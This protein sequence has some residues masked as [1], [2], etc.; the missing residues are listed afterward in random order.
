M[1]PIVQGFV[2]GGVIISG[3]DIFYERLKTKT[4]PPTS[5]S[6]TKFGTRS[7]LATSSVG[8]IRRAWVLILRFK[9]RLHPFV[10]VSS[11]AHQS[12]RANA[13]MGF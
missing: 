2:G 9:D 5:P 10:R 7:L 12:Q 6:Q 1:R 13:V 3:K 8:L 4:Y 11:D